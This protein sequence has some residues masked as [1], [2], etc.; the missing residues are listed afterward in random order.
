ME[1]KNL[2]DTVAILR[3]RVTSTPR[4]AN[5]PAELAPST[6]KASAIIIAISAAIAVFI[7]RIE[8]PLSLMISFSENILKHIVLYFTVRYNEILVQTQEFYR[9]RHRSLTSLRSI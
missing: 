3:L 5:N 7:T 2:D 9:E 8:P 1:A 4:I 6:P